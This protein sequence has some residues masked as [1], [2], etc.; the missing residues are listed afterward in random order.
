M[1][2]IKN[3]NIKLKHNKKIKKT[4][5]QTNTIKYRKF[6]SSNQKIK[7]KP[8]THLIPKNQVIKKSI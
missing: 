6:I 3:I 4:K 7:I 2:I 5:Y 8:N 1:H